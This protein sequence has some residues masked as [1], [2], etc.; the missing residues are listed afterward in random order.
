MISYTWS[1]GL[2][3][4]SVPKNQISLKLLYYLYDSMGEIDSHIW[5]LWE[6]ILRIDSVILVKSKVLWSQL[7]VIP[8]CVLVLVGKGYSYS[9]T[10]ACH[11]SLHGY[12]WR[13]RQ[14]A[15]CSPETSD[16]EISADLPGKDR[17][18]KGENGAEQKENNK[19]VLSLPKWEFFTTKKHFTPGKN[20]END[21]APSEK[22]SSYPPR[23]IA[24]G[25][26]CREDQLKAKSKENLYVT[27]TSSKK[28]KGY[29]SWYH[30]V[31]SL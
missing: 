1:Q 20:Q 12:R 10:N 17:Q 8:H 19:I 26:G 21:F 4:V 25:G 23:W 27:I 15:E 13:S 16:L 7:R 6:S 29:F 9:S 2:T 3:F 11:Q 14:G 30:K 18:G 31:W 5:M 22:Y 24:Y 28:M